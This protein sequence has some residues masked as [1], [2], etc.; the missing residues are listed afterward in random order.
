MIARP[1]AEATL[2]RAG[3]AYETA[4]Q[5]RKRRPALAATEVLERAA[6]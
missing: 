1:F 5:G 4:M 2:F 6:E 3:H